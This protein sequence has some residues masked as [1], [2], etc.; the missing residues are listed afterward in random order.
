MFKP[1]VLCSLLGMSALAV[2]AQP[3]DVAPARS[4]IIGRDTTPAAEAQDRRMSLRSALTIQRGADR[5]QDNRQAQE[6]QLSDKERAELREQLRQQR[7][8]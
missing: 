7:R 2:P 6:H 1:L 8:P 5:Q 4:P 3:V